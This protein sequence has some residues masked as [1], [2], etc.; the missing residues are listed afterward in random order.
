MTK[1]F[2]REVWIKIFV[3]AVLLSLPAQLLAQAGPAERSFAQ[4]KTSIES[5]L[6]SMQ[7]SMAGRLPT[8][9]G[10]ASPVDGRSLD[11][12][13]RAYY[14][15]T[16][17]VTPTPTG[18]VVRITAKVTAWYNDPANA[19]SGYQLLKS[20]GRLETDLLDQLEDQLAKSTAKKEPTP[21]AAV[22]AKPSA[23]QPLPSRVGASTTVSEPGIS[24]PQPKFPETDRTFSSSLKHGLA[25]DLIAKP[26]GAP[27]SE[28]ASSPLQA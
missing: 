6:K 28:S 3:G 24:A 8:L 19:H 20:N 21:A 2:V 13:Q 1:S 25:S 12:Y 14:Q 27:A 16:A 4:S 7:A 23:A 22:T 9:D 11:R 17:E 5:V 18:S 26:N 15:A 10:F